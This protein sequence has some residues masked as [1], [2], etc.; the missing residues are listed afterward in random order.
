VSLILSYKLGHLSSFLQDSGDE[1]QIYTLMDVT[2]SA[3]RTNGIEGF[4]ET[5][6]CLLLVAINKASS[7][8]VA[9]YILVNVAWGGFLRVLQGGMER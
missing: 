4:E 8:G 3:N 1:V 2:T 6:C 7:F 9:E 5:N